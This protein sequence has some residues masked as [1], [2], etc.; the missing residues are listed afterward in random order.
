MDETQARRI[1]SG[2]VQ[3][4]GNLYRPGEYLCWPTYEIDRVM[5][6]GHFAAD[7]LEAIAWWMRN[8]PQPTPSESSHVDEL[9][10]AREGH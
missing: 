7:E 9:D 6:E 8:K 1:L 3:P 4:A 5:L 2:A 10:R